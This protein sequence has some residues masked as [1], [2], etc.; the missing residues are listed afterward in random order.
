MNIFGFLAVIWV[1]IVSACTQNA[2]AFSTEQHADDK[3]HVELSQPVKDYICSEIYC[4]Q[5]FTIE[6]IKLENDKFAAAKIEVHYA[7]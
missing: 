6:Q 7:F 1:G 2:N 3:Q 5:H 4:P